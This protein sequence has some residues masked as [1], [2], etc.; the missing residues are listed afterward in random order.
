MTAK[1]KEGSVI[2]DLISKAVAKV[3]FNCE[4]VEVT[5]PDIAFG[6]YSTNVALKLAPQVKQSPLK[7]AEAIVEQLKKDKA[8]K[9]ATVAGPGFINVAM[10]DDWLD[11]QL[12]LP[13]NVAP[14]LQDKKYIIEFSSPNIAKPMHVGHLRTTIL[15][16]VLVNLFRSAG[17]N[18]VAWS[19]PGDFGTQFGKLIVGWL[20]WGEDKALQDHPID[21]LLRVYVK[22][23]Q[24]AKDDPKLEDQARQ[25]FKK[26]QDGD[27]E[28]VA[29]WQMV[30]RLSHEEFD[31]MYDKLKIKFDVWRG[32]SEYNHL[33]AQF[34]DDALEVKVACKSEGA[35][36]I[37]LDEQNLPPFLIQKSD[38]ATLY[39]TSDLVSLK[40]RA[41]EVNPDELIYVVGNEQTLHFQQLFAAAEKLAEA[42][43]YG[44][45]FEL[46]KLTHVSYGF[47]RLKTGK[48]STRQGDVIRLDE[49]IDAAVQKCDELLLAKN[50]KLTKKDREELAQTLG[51][52]AVKYTDLQ[53]DRH[54]DVVF[55]WDK[56]FALEGNSIIYL[57]YAYARC[58]SLLIK[59]TST[60]AGDGNEVGWSED[61][62]QLLFTSL[63]LNHAVRQ[64][65]EEYDP[66]HLINHVYEVASQFSR[67]YSHNAILNASAEDRARRLKL[68]AMV[69]AQ[70]QLLFDLLNIDAPE[71]L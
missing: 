17:A 62:K 48:M 69:K 44:A 53:H 63:E 36:I 59:S 49:V 4:N 24:E 1:Y 47:F 11:H 71:K 38:G 23:H 30:S 15:G 6:D 45:G 58:N 66:H 55:D 70:L 12:N 3:G 61:D 65:I 8:I 7:I 18:M 10:A 46:P 22:F 68:V 25:T 60:N 40:E 50:D 19:H 51:L 21:E 37:P 56:M 43:V 41:D 42:G 20:K 54:T 28:V 2:K 29:L 5:R 27:K 35:I 67:L 16:Q 33:L 9:S 26:L 13:L 64:S 39:A 32:E 31:R 14:T 57:I 34:V 52:A